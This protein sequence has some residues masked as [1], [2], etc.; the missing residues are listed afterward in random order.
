MPTAIPEL[1]EEFGI[2][3][4]PVIAFLRGEGYVLRRDWTWLAPANREPTERE[5]RAVMFLIQEWDM[6]GFHHEPAS[7]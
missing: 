5:L 7:S 6:G 2:D 4:A 1:R 3:D